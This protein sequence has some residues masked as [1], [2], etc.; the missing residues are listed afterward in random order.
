L[1]RSQVLHKRWVPDTNPEVMV[2]Y[3]DGLWPIVWKT[4]FPQACIW[5]QLASWYRAAA[6]SL[7]LSWRSVHLICANGFRGDYTGPV[8]EH[9]GRGLWDCACVGLANYQVYQLRGPLVPPLLS[10]RLFIRVQLT[11]EL[12]LDKSLWRLLVASGATH[13]HGACRIMMMMMMIL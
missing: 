1:D 2:I 7:P 10:W 3:T 5:I 8:L 13:W 12:A 9:L 6:V 4:S 11:I